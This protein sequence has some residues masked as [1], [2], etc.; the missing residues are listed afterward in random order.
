VAAG[1]ARRKI[2]VKNSLTCLEL[3]DVENANG[4]DEVILELLVPD[5][6][7]AQ[8]SSVDEAVQRSA[9]SFDHFSERVCAW[10]RPRTCRWLFFFICGN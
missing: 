1:G 6:A 7:H 4:A 3:V 2:I 8:K 10:L 9:A 5:V